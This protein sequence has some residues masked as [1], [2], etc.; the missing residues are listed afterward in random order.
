[1]SPRRGFSFVELLLVVTVIG[2]LVALLLPA[3]Q[4]AREAARRITC[5]K[6]LS[7]LILAVN[8]YQNLHGLYPPGTSD[9]QGPV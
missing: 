1:M 3:V 8:N 5:A 7:Q 9:D 2:I 6:N 4:A